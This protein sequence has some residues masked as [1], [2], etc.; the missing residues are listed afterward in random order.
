MSQTSGVV[1]CLAYIL[2]LLSTAI[3]GGGIGI[4]ALGIGAAIAAPRY[5][6]SGPR[7]RLWAVAGII[8][9]L[10]TLYFQVK[11]PYP[12]AN[13]VSKFVVPDGVT[14]TQ[15]VAVQG[16]VDSLPR[17]TR[18][19]RGQFWLRATQL[20]PVKAE[21]SESPSQSVSGKL[22]VTV[23]L[24]QAKGLQPGQTVTVTGSVY[25]PMPAANPQGFDFQ[26]YLEKEGTFAGLNGRRLTLLKPKPTW[27]WWT[28]RQ[29]ITQSQARWLGVPEGPLV[30]AMVLGSRAVNLP[31]EIQDEFIRV[32]LAHALAASGFQTTLI[33][34]VVL[35]LTRQLDVQKQSVFGVA[36]LITFACLSGFEPAVF[37]AVLMG[38]AGLVALVT[39]RKS[40]PVAALLGVAVLLLLYNPLWIWNL[41]FQLSFLATLGLI[42][43]VQSVIQ[44]LDWLPPAIASLLAVPIA[45]FVWTLPLQL[46]IFGSLPF[47]SILANVVTTPLISLITVGGFISSLAGLIWPLAGSA[48]AWLLYYPSHVLIALVKFFGQLPG[49]SLAVGTIDLWQL[50]VIYGLIGFVW[51][52]PWWKHRRWLA[53]LVTLVLVIVPVWQTK[54]TL[55]RAVVLA[56]SKVPIMVIQEPGWT[57]LI[58]SG[59]ERTASLTVLPFLQQQGINQIDWAI[60]TETRQQW[61][62]GWLKILQRLPI[63]NFSDV[64][65]LEVRPEYQ[66]FL[67]TLEG[68]HG[69]HLPLQTGQTISV[70]STQ[71]N[72][73]RTEPV[74]LQLQIGKLTWLFIS[75]LKSAG[76]EAGVTTTANLFQPQV[77]WW[78]GKYLTNSLLSALR[79]EVVIA[80]SSESID[81]EIV[82]QLH[83]SNVQ[84]YWTGR[85][86]AIQWT[87]D[88][89]FEKTFDQLNPVDSKLN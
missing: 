67:D 10:A 66:Q 17:L 58:N 21:Q 64:P 84:L 48:L 44:W 12:G 49:S 71:I 9:L 26:A 33:L 82:T 1:L 39:S 20:S 70:A 24:P 76:Q 28:L 36:A 83:A 42:V 81:I 89:S 78:S 13:D 63:K 34:T 73:L 46:Y 74:T 53:G 7:P 25:K 77:L 43:T 45:A 55:F 80:S 75:D 3:S 31:F 61:D 6:C 40:R 11:T 23:P 52:W 50:L 5:W 86:G 88:H 16:K 2:G 56:T 59:D 85:D 68:H 32:G 29:R 30:S 4:L 37:R 8:G 62:D 57:T 41:G 69:N 65:N 47:Y 79:P 27:G 22:Y 19:Q 60:A 54:S 18:S 14:Q 51:L 35:T 87:P 38:F 72:L 15:T